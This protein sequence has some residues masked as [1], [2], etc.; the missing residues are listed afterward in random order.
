[1]QLIFFQNCISPH[2]LPYIKEIHKMD[3]V[4]KVIYVAPVVRDSH[5]NQM[6][7][8]VFYLLRRALLSLQN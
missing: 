4:E 7:S 3:E 6:G 8:R 5:R 1:M 2:Q